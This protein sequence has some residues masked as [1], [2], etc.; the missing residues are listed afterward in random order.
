MTTGEHLVSISSVATGT[1]MD[2]LLSVIVGST[3]WTSGEKNAILAKVD[4]LHRIQ[5]LDINNPATIT[6]DLV[7]AGTI[8]LELTGDGTDLTIITRQ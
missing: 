8:N 1:A 5:G 2:H 6:P 4:E 3:G 7:S